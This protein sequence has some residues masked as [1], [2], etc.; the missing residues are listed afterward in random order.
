MEQSK[1]GVGRD[2]AVSLTEHLSEIGGM[3]R[4]KDALVFRLRSWIFWYMPMT[5]KE[6]DKW[7]RARAN[8]AYRYILKY[9]F[10]N[11]LWFAAMWT[12]LH[13]I[14]SARGESFFNLKGDLI[15]GAALGVAFRLL[16]ALSSWERNQTRYS[17]RPVKQ[18]SLKGD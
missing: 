13:D 1:H 2:R 17:L 8:G 14:L 5:Q 3:T 12:I 4:T 15:F 6:R 16:D 10:L 18:R 9:G 11:A 7:E